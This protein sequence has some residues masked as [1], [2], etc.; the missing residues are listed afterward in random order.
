MPKKAIVI[1]RITL[2]VKISVAGVFCSAAG[3]GELGVVGDDSKLVG[4]TS[5]TAWLWN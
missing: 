4:I 3:A 1:Q 2:G 5:G